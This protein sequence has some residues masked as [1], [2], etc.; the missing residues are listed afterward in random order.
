VYRLSSAF[1]CRLKFPD[2]HYLVTSRVQPMAGIRRP[3][4]RMGGEARAFPTFSPDHGNGTSGSYYISCYID[5]NS[6]SHLSGGLSKVLA[7]TVQES[8]PPMSHPPTIIVLPPPSF[9]LPDK[10]GR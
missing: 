10:G 2:S 8:P 6:C 1:P 7:I 9:V 5:C 3:E 4:G